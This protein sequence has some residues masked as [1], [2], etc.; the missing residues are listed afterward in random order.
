M[1]GQ[2][3]RL[4]SSGSGDQVLSGEHLL[5][6]EF[7]IFTDEYHQASGDIVKVKSCRPGDKGNTCV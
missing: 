1:V 7:K 2:L 3:V 5:Q 4:L 6:T